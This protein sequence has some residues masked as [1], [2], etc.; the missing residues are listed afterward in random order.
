MLCDIGPMASL[1]PVFQKEQP[2][3]GAD[4]SIAFDQYKLAVEMWDRV[5][6]RRQKMNAFYVTITSALMTAVTALAK[7]HFGMTLIPSVTGIV[8]C[9]LWFETILRYKELT[10]DKQSVIVSM[11]ALFPCSPFGA[12]RKRRHFTLIERII[13][14]TFIA[15]F[16]TIISYAL[17]G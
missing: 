6:E 4:A 5:R 12:E 14:L 17:L 16:V 11:E 2:L 10:D 9:L 3:K 1:G 7:D 15:L 8:I 13:P